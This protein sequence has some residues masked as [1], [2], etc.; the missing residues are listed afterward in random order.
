MNLI[1]LNFLCLLVPAS[2]LG[3]YVTLL[4]CLLLLFFK[5]IYRR[6]Q[7]EIKE[8]NLDIFGET[9][10]ARIEEF[11]TVSSLGEDDVESIPSTRFNSVT[12][13]L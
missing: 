1:N 8:K 7:E 13:V 11:Q 6:R 3:G 5:P 9:C 4:C 2:V 10:D 12:T